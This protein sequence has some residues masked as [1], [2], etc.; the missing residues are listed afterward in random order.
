[1]GSQ[2]PLWIWILDR[3]D[4]NAGSLKNLLEEMATTHATIKDTDSLHMEYR[5]VP[6][7]FYRE[8][9][10]FQNHGV[11]RGRIISSGYKLHS[12]ASLLMVR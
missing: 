12:Y 5:G 11:A 4:A 2:N 8:T 6:L 10:P 3:H 9:A 1:M 7:I